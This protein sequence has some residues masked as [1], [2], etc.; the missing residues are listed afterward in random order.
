MTS[1]T[2]PDPTPVHALDGPALDELE[3]LLGG[4]F[5]PAHG[6][7]LPGQAPPSWPDN[8][9]LAV[10]VGLGETARI[11]GALVLSDPD[12]TPLARLT[13][14]DSTHLSATVMNLAGELVPLRPAEHPPARGLRLTQPLPKPAGRR[15]LLAAFSGQPRAAQMA[16]TAATARREEADIWFVAVCGPQPHGRYTVTGLMTTLEQCAAQL[17]DSSVGLVI[18]PTSVDAMDRHDRLL[19]G[20]VLANLGADVL[21]DFTELAE[22][23]D[24]VPAQQ[25]GVPGMGAVVF[26]TGLSGSGKS[27][28]A[29]ALAGHLQHSDRRPVTLL[30]G[31]D[32]RRLLSSGLGFSK[33]DR[34]INIRRV[35]W[36]ASL[37]ARSGGIAVCAPIAPFDATR[38]EV[39]AMAADAGT[40]LL[41][42]VST[43]LQVCEQRDRK[44]LY[45]RARAGNLPD[46]T[47]I[48]SPY[49][50]PEDA[51]VVIDTWCTGVQEAAEQIVDALALRAKPERSTPERSMQEPCPAVADS[52]LDG[53][54][55]TVAR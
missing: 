38:Q 53:A 23:P 17:P 40:F 18:M 54:R 29:R 49:E 42:H 8:F 32:V 7:C 6:Y 2:S 39:R 36:V 26:L 50:I 4:L 28:I 55:L 20:H 45:A 14:S 37:I 13:I 30:D 11:Q 33:E 1:W 35:G 41:V 9:T 52:R 16:M 3:L 51:D 21:L 34:E 47:G 19:R 27:T 12:G 22:T 5:A 15:T 46:F 43:P 48:D 25:A 10:P 44:G 31:D 24:R